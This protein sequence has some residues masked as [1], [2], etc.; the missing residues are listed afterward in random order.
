MSSTI[1]KEKIAYPIGVYN[2]NLSYTTERPVTA[3]ENLILELVSEQ[4]LHTSEEVAEL[5]ETLKVE[6]VFLEEALEHLKSLGFIE[7]HSGAMRLSKAGQKFFKEK[8][9]LSR[10]NEKLE[11]FI[12]YASENKMCSRKEDAWKEIE[13]EEIEDRVVKLKEVG[14]HSVVLE[15][16]CRFDLDFEYLLEF[17]N[18]NSNSLK[19]YDPN[20]TEIT[21][22]TDYKHYEAI[23]QRFCPLTLE[24]KIDDNNNL[25]IHTDSKDFDAWLE[26][27]DKKVVYQELVRPF[28]SPRDENAKNLDLKWSE[29]RT[30]QI[31]LQVPSYAKLAL[32][33]G[34]S[35]HHANSALPWEESP[36][37][38]PK[39]IPT[40][41][42]DAS[43]QTPSL[44]GQHLKLPATNSKD[45]EGSLCVYAI[46]DREKTKQILYANM[47]YYY[48]NSRYYTPRYIIMAR[49]WDWQN[50]W[51]GL[52]CVYNLDVYVFAAHFIEK[53][54]WV[55]ALFSTRPEIN[56][57]EC[58]ELCEKIKQTWKQD[59]GTK[60]WLEYLPLLDNSEDL[61]ITRKLVGGD[62]PL[63][64]LSKHFVEKLIKRSMQE[65]PSQVFANIQVPGIKNYCALQRLLKESKVSLE[66]LQKIERGIKEFKELL[67]SCFH[68]NFQ[69][70]LQQLQDY[71]NKIDQNFKE[72]TQEKYAL[73]DL[74]LLKQVRV[75]EIKDRIQGRVLL[76]A[77][78]Q[79]LELPQG[80]LSLQEV[81]PRSFLL[82]H[83]F[84]NKDYSKLDQI[85]ACAYHYCLNDIVIYSNNKNLTS[86][87]HRF[88]LKV[89]V[90]ESSTHKNNK[91]KSK[92]K[93]KR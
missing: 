9:A 4:I 90:I 37:P 70:L 28:L 75:K 93:G 54:E 8:K 36:Y 33:W 31:A 20:N 10:G 80:V 29:V 26:R 68:P 42:Y 39:N 89:E 87:A 60:A 49:A 84:G 76:K 18:R 69:D 92:K 21:E 63:A 51:Q 1:L 25:S 82:Q 48:N 11:F 43:I 91:H 88:G 14:Y 23:S 2:L 32:I 78:M 41:H 73:L 7:E 12:D 86:D 52:L 55:E 47:P 24:L 40:I 16:V 72:P 46:K 3:F 45:S 77:S 5:A 58:V 67:Q 71:K 35:L 85:L 6:V 74:D 53:E 17:L 56:L 15:D 61:K 30:G 34:E 83:M 50:F 38:V 22:I 59:M 62:I 13:E 79:E 65:D 27:L 57:Q 44:Q 66:T 64:K 19:W 81:S